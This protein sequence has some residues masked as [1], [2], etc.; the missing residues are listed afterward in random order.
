MSKE[1]VS[2]LLQVTKYFLYFLTQ[3]EEWLYKKVK[4]NMTL[5]Y[6]WKTEDSKVLNDLP[7]ARYFES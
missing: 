6:K 3:L 2:K 1:M 4:E 5:I 7:R